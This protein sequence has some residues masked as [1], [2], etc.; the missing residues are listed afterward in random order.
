MKNPF[1][2]IITVDDVNILYVDETKKETICFGLNETKLVFPNSY[3]EPVLPDFDN[4]QTLLISDTCVCGTVYFY[5][6]KGGEFIKMFHKT[7]I[8]YAAPREKFLHYIFGVRNPK[9]STIDNEVWHGQAMRHLYKNRTRAI[10]SIS[11]QDLTANDFK[12]ACE[13]KKQEYLKINWPEPTPK[14]E[15]LPQVKYKNEFGITQ[16]MPYGALIEKMGQNQRH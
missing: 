1:K 3:T 14:L 16:V 11:K 9:S 4:S 13:L 2:K 8:G 12:K 5:C 6:M 10:I 7:K 15:A